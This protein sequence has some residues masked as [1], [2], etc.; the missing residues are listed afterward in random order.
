MG[1]MNARTH[2]VKDYMMNVSDGF[3]P[4][5]NMVNP[6]DC[7][8]T[9]MNTDKTVNEYGKKLIDLCIT[10]QLRILNGRTLGD[11]TGKCTCF[12]Y[13]GCSAIDYAIVDQ[14]LLKYVT[15]F[16]VHCYLEDISDHCPIGLYIRS[17]QS[18]KE[19]D[20]GGGLTAPPR[21]KWNQATEN[22]LLITLNKMWQL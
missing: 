13:N 8:M 10:T 15:L 17:R 3:H 2:R 11:I 7:L 6:D 9:R 22:C 19:C 18:R 20:S 21:C 12:K 1:D 5:N 14:S 4:F 16:T